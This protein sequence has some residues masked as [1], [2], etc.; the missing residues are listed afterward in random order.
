MCGEKTQPYGV[1]SVGYF[2]GSC[3][4]FGQ[5]ADP[6]FWTGLGGVPAEHSC[7]TAGHQ[8]HKDLWARSFLNSADWIL[9]EPP[10]TAGTKS[11]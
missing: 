10:E 8:G 3:G 1:V 5:G 4:E 11:N 6:T 2:R 9:R 7:G